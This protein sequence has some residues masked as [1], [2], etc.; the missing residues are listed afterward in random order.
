[1]MMACTFV[2]LPFAAMAQTEEKPLIEFKTAILE[3]DGE[4]T[5]RTVTIF[6]AGHKQE[7]DYIDSTAE[8]GSRSMN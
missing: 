8:T 5:G 6:L 4:E 7:T 1:M 2:A 3:Q